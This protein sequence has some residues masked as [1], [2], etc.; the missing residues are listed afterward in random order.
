MFDKAKEI[1]KFRK[2]QSEMKKELENIFA[3]VEKSGVRIVIRG[4]K[5]IEKITVDEEE[6]RLLKDV[7]NDSMKEVDKKVEKQMRGKLGD[8]GI[9]GL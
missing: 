5:H 3:T 2:M 7:L 8:F 1:L 6:Q 9:P 4:D